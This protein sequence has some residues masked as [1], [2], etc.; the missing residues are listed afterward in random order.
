MTTAVQNHR[1]V[2]DTFLDH[3]QV[4]FDKGDLLQASEK[5]WGALAHYVKAIAKGREWHNE[6]HADLMRIAGGLVDVTKDS[7]SQRERLL[8]VRSLHSNFYEDEFDSDE[9][10]GGIDAAR[11]LLNALKEAEPNFPVRQPRRKR[12]PRE[13]TAARNKPN[14]QGGMGPR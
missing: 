12:P 10:Q 2:S 1:S 3:A 13:V 6:T 5:A 4:E 14:E 8:A 9:V 7:K 11:K